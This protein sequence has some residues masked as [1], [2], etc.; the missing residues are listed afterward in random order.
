MRGDAYQRLQERSRRE[1]GARRDL[2]GE[3]DRRD[4]NR[5]QSLRSERSDYDRSLGADERSWVDRA[6]DEVSG[7]FGGDRDNRNQTRSARERNFNE[8][9]GNSYHSYQADYT[10]KEANPFYPTT[11]RIYERDERDTERGEFSN[12]NRDY[13]QPRGFV[14]PENQNTR[15]QPARGRWRDWHD[16]RAGDLMS[17]NV[18]TVQPNETV[19]RAARLMRDED[20]GALPVLDRQGRIIGMITDRDI[21]VRIVADGADPRYAQVQDCMT[22][23]VFACHA[24]DPI[25]GCIRT[26]K[27]H[28]VRRIPVINDRNQLLGIISQG[29]LAR[30]ADINKQ[31]G[32]RH[33]VTDMIAGVSEPSN[34][35]YR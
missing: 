35:A 3:S 29:D 21:T 13:N 18:A 32:E 2:P 17:R 28:Q 31:Q 22:D 24:D 12:Q 26:M 4:L 23:D 8:Y 7:W 10:P 20:C 14:A 27:Q 34:S 15:Q 33:A 30:H 9:D 6:A 5:P 11:N 16:T 1:F 25:E 19:Q